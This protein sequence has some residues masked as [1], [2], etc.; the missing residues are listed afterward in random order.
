MSTQAGTSCHT[1]F[2]IK[3]PIYLSGSNKVNNRPSSGQVSTILRG[4]NYTKK[5]KCLSIFVDRRN[6]P[7]INH[8]AFWC[9][10]VFR[11]AKFWL[12]LIYLH[13]FEFKLELSALYDWF[14]RTFVCFCLFYLFVL[15]FFLI[16]GRGVIGKV[17]NRL[18][19]RGRAYKLF[20]NF[21]N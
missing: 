18:T 2:S 16:W 14:V 21:K 15:F 9:P 12:H 20:Q 17:H 11:S 13:L 5:I 7:Y 3:L 19:W 6:R 1:C 10:K 8:I 4:S